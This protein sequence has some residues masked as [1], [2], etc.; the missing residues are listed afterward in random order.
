VWLGGSEGTRAMDFPGPGGPG[1][2]VYFVAANNVHRARFRMAD[3]SVMALA[4]SGE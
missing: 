2:T 4:S 1:E 3:W